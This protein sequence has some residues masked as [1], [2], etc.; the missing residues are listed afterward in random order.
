MTALRRPRSGTYPWEVDTATT[1]TPAD[2]VVL[3]T[4][5][6]VAGR[7]LGDADDALA[8]LSSVP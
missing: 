2:A 4:P 5:A 3:A 1:T 6:P 7:L 8:A